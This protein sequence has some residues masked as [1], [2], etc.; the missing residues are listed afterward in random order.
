VK[1][2]NLDTINAKTKTQH[3]NSFM[4]FCGYNANL[5]QVIERTIYLEGED[6]PFGKGSDMYGGGGV[7]FDEDDEEI[8]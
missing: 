4:L 1:S 5:V 2:L 6:T 8:S 3:N 7:F